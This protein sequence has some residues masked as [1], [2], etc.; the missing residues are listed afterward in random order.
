[1]FSDRALF[2]RALIDS[3]MP[4]EMLFLLLKLS[5][6]NCDTVAR[7]AQLGPGQKV[8]AF[9]TYVC[10]DQPWRGDPSK[11]GKIA[12]AILRNADKNDR[13]ATLGQK[14]T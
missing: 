13:T 10:F 9:L 7:V 12:R 8:K 14:C 2:P 11:M 3:Q 1:M 6:S 5:P 4:S